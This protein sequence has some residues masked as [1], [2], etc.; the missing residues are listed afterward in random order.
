MPIDID[1]EKY[2]TAAEAARYLQISR[3]TFYQN[4]KDRLQPYHL[5]AFRRLHYRQ[6]DLDRFKGAQTTP[7]DE[8]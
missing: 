2:Y 1:G 3:E 8:R 4:V 6:T 5:G 7:F